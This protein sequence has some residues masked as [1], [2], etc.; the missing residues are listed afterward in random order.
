M[1]K[2]SLTLALATLLLTVPSSFAQ[3]PTPLLTKSEPEL[4]AVL[5]AADST[6]KQK[7]DACLELSV[8]GTK[9]AVPALAALLPN[10]ELNHMA[11]YALETIPDSSVDDALRAQLATLTG[12]PLVGVI[13]SIGVRKDAAAVP[14]LTL[15]LRDADPDVAQAAARAL[16]RIGTE[17]AVAA[18]MEAVGETSE[19][20]LVAFCEGIGRGLDALFAAGKREVVAEIG[21]NYRNTSLPH[22]VRSA[23]LRGAIRAA[24]D[25]QRLLAASLAE[26]EYTLFATAVRVAQEMPGPETTRTLAASLK[27]ASPDRQ[28]VILQTL[29]LS[30]DA[31]ALPAITELTKSSVKAVRLAAVRAL[32][33]LA[34]AA[35]V[36]DLASLAADPDREIAQAAQDG[37]ASIPGPQADA[38]IT[39]LLASEAASQRALGLDLIGKRRLTQAMPAVIKATQDADAGVRVAAIRRLGEL[40]GAAEVPVLAGVLTGAKSNPE[41]DAAEQA[42]SGLAVRV[43]NPAGTVA[44]VRSRLAGLDAAKSAAMLRVLGALGGPEALEV[45]RAALGSQDAAIRADAIRVLSDWRTADAAPDLLNLARS[46]A[47]ANDKM[48]GLRGYVGFAS[49]PDLP[50]EQ[51]LAICR[52]AA[53]VAQRPEEKRLLLGALGSI[54]NVAAVELIT[55]HLQAADTK[56]E[57][58][59][60]LVAVA[61][62]LLK[63]NDASAKAV[64]AQLVAPLE[65]AGNATGNADLAKRVKTLTERAQAKAK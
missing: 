19:A 5:T 63:R 43:G 61:D 18:I 17:S 3:Q 24:G 55:P 11:R 44:L 50:V 56:E 21:A 65:A 58:V 62:E 57:A 36:P 2:S 53:T 16:G 32:P 42:L 29:G 37:L 20:N 26:V 47:T 7:A 60:A 28:I 9:N 10:P 14:A 25:P 15:R 45:V 13:G 23:A 54:K 59:A 41:L 35:A 48:L 22:Q 39:A 38:A 1:L 64:A 49:N 12:R 46:A 4:L 31:S 33:M 34:N 40:G 30:G 6:R 27:T 8:I 51:R 52:E